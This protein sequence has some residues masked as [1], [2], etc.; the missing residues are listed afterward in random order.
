MSEQFDISK[1]IISIWMKK[2]REECQNKPELKAE[3]DYI[4]EIRMLKKELEEK[5][6]ENLFLY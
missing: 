2:Y 6:K 3:Y 1:A 5:E 4:T